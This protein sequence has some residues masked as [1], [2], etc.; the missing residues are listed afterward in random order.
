MSSEVVRRKKVKRSSRS[1]KAGDGDVRRTRKRKRRNGELRG[2]SIVCFVAFGVVL[3]ALKVY[4]MPS[5]DRHGIRHGENY[6]MEMGKL[7]KNYKRDC[8]RNSYPYKVYHESRVVVTLLSFASEIT[9]KT[10]C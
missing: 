5:K 7:Q 6:K 2:L 1:V 8:L 4:L 9:S 10:F 3:L